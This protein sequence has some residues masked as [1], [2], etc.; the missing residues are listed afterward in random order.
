[1]AYERSQGFFSLWVLYNICEEQ[2]SLDGEQGALVSAPHGAAN[3]LN[4]CLR[5]WKRSC[6]SGANHAAPF[7]STS[8]FPGDHISHE[9]LISY[10]QVKCYPKAWAPLDP[11]QEVA[12]FLLLSSQVLQTRSRVSW[13]VG[14]AWHKAWG[15][16]NTAVKALPGTQM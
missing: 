7:I 15:W 2:W 16:N 14:E 5:H 13:W 3:M 11:A 8:P 4:P 1:M 9:E 12:V 6:Q 10:T